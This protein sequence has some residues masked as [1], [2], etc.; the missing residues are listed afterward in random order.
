M[1]KRYEGRGAK[2]EEE[3]NEIKEGGKEETTWKNVRNE[4]YEGRRKTE[5]RKRKEGVGRGTKTEP[6]THTNEGKPQRSTNNPVHTLR[7]LLKK[8]KEGEREGTRECKDK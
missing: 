8:V 1:R 7:R 3:G 5:R 4:A 6:R 2:E